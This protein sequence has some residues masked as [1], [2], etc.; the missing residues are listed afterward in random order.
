VMFFSST[1]SSLLPGWELMQ[2]YVLTKINLF[3]LFHSTGVLFTVSRDKLSEH[4]PPACCALSEMHNYNIH[5]WK[6]K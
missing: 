5:C 6:K 2:L 1:P 4:A 3:E